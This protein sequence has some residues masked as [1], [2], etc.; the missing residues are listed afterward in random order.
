MNT[1]PDSSQPLTTTLVPTPAP[2][3]AWTLDQQ[4]LSDVYNWNIAH[5]ENTFHR[6]VKRISTSI[7]KHD[8]LFEL[9]PD[10]PI[11][12]RGVVQAV[13]HV[14]KLGAVNTS[15]CVSCNEG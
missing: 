12:I 11:P 6:M 2:W 9:V 14:V 8:V 7:E 3:E 15:I 10:G 5:P 13:A 1:F 4:F